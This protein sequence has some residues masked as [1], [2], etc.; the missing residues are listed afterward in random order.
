M[1]E[2]FTQVKD[3]PFF[4][5]KTILSD[6]AKQT[7]GKNVKFDETVKYQAQGLV[8]KFEPLFAYEFA[9]LMG[10]DCAQ[11]KNEWFKKA[12]ELIEKQE[13]SSGARLLV[14]LEM[15]EVFG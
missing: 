2:G 3:A 15:V 14:E 7:K 10:L 8:G 5:T 9:C 1:L 13:I 6:L 11:D 4:I 12:V